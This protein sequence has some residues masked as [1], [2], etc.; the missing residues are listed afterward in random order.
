M[1]SSEFSTFVDPYPYQSALR[2]EMEIYP[3][4]RGD[5]Q[6][7]LTKVHLRRLW[8]QRSRESLPRIL[9][10]KV[11]PG[12]AAICF[13]VTRN[14]PPI[15]HCGIDISPGDIIVD[16]S[17]SM[18]RRSDGPSHS[19][20]MSLSPE[21]LIEAGID[22]LGHEL[23]VPR[24]THVVRPRPALMSRLL[25]LHEQ[26]GQLAR[27]APDRLAKPQV[28]QA[29]EQELV[30]AMVMCLAEATTGELGVAGCR[31]SVVMARLE[32]FLTANHD[33][34]VYLMEI[35]AAT[36]ASERTL[37]DCCQ[38]QMGMSPIRYLWLRR[39][40]LARRALV[41]A[42]P[43]TANVTEIATE[44]GFWELGR[45]STE[46]RT[47]FGEPPSVSLRRAQDDR[48]MSEVRSFALPASE[49]A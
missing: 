48:Q 6:A 31:H 19:G 16:S 37:R 43:T 5:F 21:D 1:V 3:T 22:L 40:H 8:V 11:P 30:H 24:L 20:A 45:F 13:L 26:V 41:L 39:M 49:F 29:L 32:E 44:Y 17:D 15:R 7:E 38:E 36:G 28:A 2:G 27:T 42:N 34:P 35:C 9:V 23:R 4:A 47:L 33:R 10:G 25:N 46:Y 14:A 18:H 12:R